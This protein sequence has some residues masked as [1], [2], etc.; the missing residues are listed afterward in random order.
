[1][2]RVAHA[3]ASELLSW[4]HFYLGNDLGTA[5]NRRKLNFIA[6]HQNERNEEQLRRQV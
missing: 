2:K 4:R 6:S 1:M 3:F 5:G